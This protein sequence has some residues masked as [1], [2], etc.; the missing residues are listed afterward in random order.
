MCLLAMGL[1]LNATAQYVNG[2]A[3]TTASQESFEEKV[4][5]W[6]EV[7]VAIEG[8]GYHLPDMQIGGQIEDHVNTTTSIHISYHHGFML[9]QKKPF[10]LETGIG[11]KWG[12]YN[13]KYEDRIVAHTGI[14]QEILNIWTF[15]AP[16]NVGYRFHKIG[17]DWSFYPYTGLYFRL[18]LT[19]TLK[20]QDP[21]GNKASANIFDQDEFYP[22]FKHFQCGWQLGC[23]FQYRKFVFGWSYGIDFN[24][25]WTDTRVF[26]SALNL[27]YRF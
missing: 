1:A 7:R 17:S 21:Y 19:G 4:T 20:A 16:I 2:M 18:H 8:N 13:E 22:T 14:K 23:D 11:V 15:E 9:S 24:K 27:G 3:A 26:T 5:D 12:H 10:F 6:D 25:V